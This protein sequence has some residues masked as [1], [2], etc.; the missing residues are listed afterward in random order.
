M[1]AHVGLG[2][3]SGAKQR[4]TLPSRTK[5]ELH[6]T[7]GEDL[8][9]KYKLDTPPCVGLRASR[10]KAHNARRKPCSGVTNNC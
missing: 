7:V 3:G 8:L 6:A 9:L 4:E 2:L 5:G 1:P 10:Q